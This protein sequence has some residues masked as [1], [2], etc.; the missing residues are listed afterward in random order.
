MVKIT[1]TE[2]VFLTYKLENLYK[3]FLAEFRKKQVEQLTRTLNLCAFTS[4]YHQ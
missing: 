3:V 2:T 4:A 1:K